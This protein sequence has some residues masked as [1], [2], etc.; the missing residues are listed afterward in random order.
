[1]S[2]EKNVK[3]L[4]D[5]T[6]S[7]LY[8][9]VP[10]QNLVRL[11]IL[12]IG[13][14][15]LM[16]IGWSAVTSVNEVTRAQ[17]E[18]IP[19]GYAQIVQHLEGGIVSEILVEEG[20]LV[21]EGEVLVR[22]GGVGA[23]QD[24]ASLRERQTTLQLQAERLRALAYDKTPDFSKIAGDNADAVAYQEKLLEAARQANASERKVVEGQLAQKEQAIERLNAQKDTAQ[25]ELESAQEV[26][27]MKNDMVKKGS[28]S[29]KDVIDSERDVTQ[30]Q[31]DLNA[32]EAQI[33]EAQ[34]AIGEYQ[35]RL[36]NLEA[37][38][39]DDALQE[40]EEVETQIA[41]NQE[42][43]GKLEGRVDR[44]SVRAPVRG[45]VKGLRVNTVGGVIGGGEPLMEIIPLDRTLIVEARILPREVG[46]LKVG[47][48]A[49][50]KVS[51]FDFSRYGFIEGKLEFLSATTF[52]DENQ[53][54]YYKGRISLSKDHVGPNEQRN[55]ILPGMTVEADII[56]GEKT[57][58][59]YLLKP[60]HTS[61]D[62]AF[63]ER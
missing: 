14:G 3:D 29:R 26:L 13:I 37:R 4:N 54:S 33:A 25:K 38:T 1:M 11:T 42:T 55:L 43:L 53:N 57:V 40:L 48:P 16:F 6:R 63:R 10:N 56:T 31:G 36:Q 9:E 59:A 28:V 50:V 49:S 12:V 35:S 23:E 24:F 41:Q 44:Q 15:A 2:D 30:R 27:T 62:T 18:I 52:V 5:L 45:L 51:A 20:D 47:Q 21:E 32:L 58:L 34:Q 7:V 17:G 61:L 39:S 19:S 60:I 22:M 8:E 46:S